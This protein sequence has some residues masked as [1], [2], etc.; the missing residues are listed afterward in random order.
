MSHLWGGVLCI[1]QDDDNDKVDEIAAMGLICKTSALTIVAASRERLTDS[2]LGNGNF[3]FHSCGHQ[4][5]SIAG[6][7][8][9]AILKHLAP[10]HSR[11]NAYAN[12][13]LIRRHSR[14]HKAPRR[15]DL[16]LSHGAVSR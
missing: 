2:F 12:E 9:R 5:L 7:W 4:G 14:M 11:W 6:F 10:D 15:P 13:D 1:V 3:L 8:G 16:V